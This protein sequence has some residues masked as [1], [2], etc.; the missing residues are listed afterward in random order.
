MKLKMSDTKR[1]RMAIFIQESTKSRSRRTLL[2]SYF[3]F[4]RRRVLCFVTQSSRSSMIHDQRLT[5]TSNALDD[6]LPSVFELKSSG[7][8][9]DRKHKSF[10]CLSIND[11]FFFSGIT[12]V[13]LLGH[14]NPKTAT[15]DDTKMTD[16][17]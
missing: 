16:Q 15:L 7:P 10:P 17:P 1:C 12:K 8:D 14:G 6:V 4:M 2:E 11:S 3:R 9:G 13:V 5:F